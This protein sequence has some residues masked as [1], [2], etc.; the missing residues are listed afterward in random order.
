MSGKNAR[1]VRKG[2]NALNHS[3]QE[4]ANEVVM[5]LL[6]APFKYRFSFAMKLIFHRRK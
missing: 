1:M 5:E 2:I 3:K 4:T 6:N